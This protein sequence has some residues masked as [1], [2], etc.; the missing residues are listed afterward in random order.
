MARARVYKQLIARA[1]NVQQWEGASAIASAANCSCRSV[2]RVTHFVQLCRRAVEQFLAC[3]RRLRQ[4]AL[5][6]CLVAPVSLGSALVSSCVRSWPIILAKAGK[7]QC[8]PTA[9]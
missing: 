2:R 3:K 8:P 7:P 5:P 9:S 4:L 6:Q 1:R